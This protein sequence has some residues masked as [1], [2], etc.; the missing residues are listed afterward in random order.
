MVHYKWQWMRSAD[1][2][3]T[4]P[5]MMALGLVFGH[6]GLDGA[7]VVSSGGVGIRGKGRMELQTLLISF[8]APFVDYL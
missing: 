2:D 8:E 3:K 5:A 7:G 1:P 6:L 4:N